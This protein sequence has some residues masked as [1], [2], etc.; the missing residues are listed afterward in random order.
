MASQVLPASTTFLRG[1][2]V[3]KESA[4]KVYCGLDKNWWKQLYDG[5]FHHLGVE[6]FDKALHRLRAEPGFY[7]SAFK[8][9]EFAKSHLTEKLSVDFYLGLHKVACAHFKGKENNTEMDSSEAGRFRVLGGRGVR[10]KIKLR[11]MLEEVFAVEKSKEIIDHYSNLREDLGDKIVEICGEGITVKIEDKVTRREDTCDGGDLEEIENLIQKKFQALNETLD[12]WANDPI[13]KH[14]IPK[15]NLIGNE[16]CFFY[17]Q[18]WFQM[19]ITTLFLDFNQTLSEINEELINTPLTEREKIDSLVERK[20]VL[21]K[22]LFQNL[23]WLH[24]FRDGQGRTDLLLL[25]KLLSEN[26]FTPAILEEPYMSSFSS[27]EE[28]LAYLKEGMQKW[29]EE[30]KKGT[31]AL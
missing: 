26:G 25:A 16:L 29:E 9:F 15:I 21:I 28:W 31:E 13:V 10:C 3:T 17:S 6:V 1:F 19:V 23:E 18:A 27:R 30:R 11:M 8:A 12:E 2:P 20:L 14:A 7:D 4:E 24:P 5:K 22:N